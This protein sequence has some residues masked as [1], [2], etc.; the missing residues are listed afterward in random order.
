M[1]VL[2]RDVLQRI[3]PRFPGMGFSQEIKLLAF[4]HPALH[5]REVY[6]PYG[7]RLGQS[8]LRPWRHGWELIVCLVRQRLRRASA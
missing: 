5:C 1:W 4:R 6:V 8:K 7:D 2:R 3:R